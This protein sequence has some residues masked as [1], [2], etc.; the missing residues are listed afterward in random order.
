[1]VLV[2]A[3]FAEGFTG[4]VIALV[5]AFAVALPA[6]ALHARFAASVAGGGEARARVVAGALGAHL[7]SRGWWTLAALLACTAL[8]PPF[9]SL[10]FETLA[11]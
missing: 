8:F 10:G 9:F 5:V 4:L 6:K 11:I 2:A 3:I 1:M 7:A